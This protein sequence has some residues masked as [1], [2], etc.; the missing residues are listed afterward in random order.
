MAM[1]NIAYFS[2]LIPAYAGNTVG[3]QLVAVLT[4][5]HPRLR[6]EH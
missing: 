6:G 2:R 5:A 1:E 3:A 4:A